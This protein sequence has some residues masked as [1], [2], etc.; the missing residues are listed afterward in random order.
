[1]NM[2]ILKQIIKEA[3]LQDVGYEEEFIED[4]NV[5]LSELFDSLTN[6]FGYN[7][8]KAIQDAEFNLN[9]KMLTNMLCEEFQ[10]YQF[11]VR[12]FDEVIKRYHDNSS[13]VL[14]VMFF[15]PNSCIADIKSY[16]CWL[17]YVKINNID[18]NGTAIGDAIIHVSEL[19]RLIETDANDT[20]LTLCIE[21]V[22]KAF[23][24]AKLKFAHS[25]DALRGFIMTI[26]D[27]SVVYTDNLANSIIELGKNLYNNG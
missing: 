15:N 26:F 6:N 5:V 8:H 3:L 20:Q 14:H 2:N 13:K 1:M 23:A 7:I 16:I 19:N 18:T 22:Y 25:P 10:S 24:R 27:G 4:A 17:I 12:L 9:A 21:N 11:A